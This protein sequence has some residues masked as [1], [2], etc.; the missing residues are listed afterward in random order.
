M[1]HRRRL[2]DR[3]IV[4]AVYPERDHIQLLLST[5]F[6]VE[7]GGGEAIDFAVMCCID[8]ATHSESRTGEREMA[9]PD[10]RNTINLEFDPVTRVFCRSIVKSMFELS[11]LTHTRLETCSLL[12]SRARPTS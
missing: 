9:E 5:V 8:K 3:D 7:S 1:S 12:A 10:A 11:F 2:I 4:S 6:V